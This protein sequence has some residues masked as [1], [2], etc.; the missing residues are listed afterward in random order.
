MSKPSIPAG[1]TRQHSDE[2][3][4]V[5]KRIFNKSAL[6]CDPVSEQMLVSVCLYEMTK[7]LETCPSPPL[8][9]LWKLLSVPTNRYVDPQKSNMNTRPSQAPMG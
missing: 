4:D 9:N 3:L 2:D 7:D 1:R 6:D 8:A 5:Y